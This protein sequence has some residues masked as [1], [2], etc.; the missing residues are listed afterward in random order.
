MTKEQIE[1]I[2]EKFDNNGDGKMSKKEFKQLMALSK[3]GGVKKNSDG[4]KKG[5]TKE[6]SDGPKKN[7]DAPKRKPGRPRKRT[8]S[9]DSDDDVD[10]YGI[11]KAWVRETRSSRSNTGKK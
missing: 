2:F 6:T 3:K 4:P 8:V 11:P 10:R 1:A 7:P 9:E 5:G